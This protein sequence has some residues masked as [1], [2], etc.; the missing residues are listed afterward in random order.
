MDKKNYLYIPSG[1]F[2]Y[3]LRHWVENEIT[4]CL[5]P[6][7]LVSQPID[8]PRHSLGQAFKASKGLFTLVAE[9][10]ELISGIGPLRALQEIGKFSNWQ[11]SN[12]SNS[13]F[14]VQCEPALNTEN[15][16]P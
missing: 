13:I 7:S 3:L 12:V 14:A 1:I 16:Y 6:R 10:C 5:L 15:Y 9:H 4:F 2:Y 8:L 11:R